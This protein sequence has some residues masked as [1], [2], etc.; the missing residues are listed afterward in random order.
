[1]SKSSSKGLRIEEPTY[2]SICGYK[3]RYALVGNEVYIVQADVAKIISMQNDHFCGFCK[4]YGFVIRLYYPHLNAGSGSSVLAS[5]IYSLMW[6]LEFVGTPAALKVK[7]ELGRTSFEETEEIVE[8]EEDVGANLPAK[9]DMKEF[10]FGNTPIRVIEKDGNPWFVASEVCGALG[11]S[12]PEDA[13]RVVDEDD[14]YLI[15][16]KAALCAGLE[17]GPRGKLLVN[18]SGVYQVIFQSNKPEAKRFKKWVTRE[19]LPEIRKTGSYS[20]PKTR[21]QALA[22][23]VLIANTMIEEQKLQIE[24][25]QEYIEE[26]EPLAEGYKTFLDHDGTLTFTDCANSMGIPGLTGAR[27]TYFLRDQK[28]LGKWRYAGSKG[29]YKNLPLQKYAGLGWF[30][31]VDQAIYTP[32]GSPGVACQCRLTTKGQEEIRKIVK[33]YAEDH[34]T[35]WNMYLSLTNKEL[36]VHDRED[37]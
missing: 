36:S 19:V 13:L 2:I 3:V 27:L 21:E 30:S 4:P 8:A 32:D 18:E 31:V 12:R 37:C 33:Q 20:V 5:Q 6:A 35:M 7:E 17:I 9:K 28:Y 26:I 16:Q 10:Y 24:Y 23:A 15:S 25:Q 1:M 11:F 34:P 22:E 14:K 29:R